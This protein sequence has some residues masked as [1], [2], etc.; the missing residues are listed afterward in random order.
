LR[1][2]PHA[3]IGSKEWS[4]H[5]GVEPEHGLRTYKPRKKDLKRVR[6]LFPPIFS[7]AL[8]LFVVSPVDATQGISDAIDTELISR[9]APVYFSGDR[10]SYNLRR[11]LVLG[12][13]RIEVIQGD[14]RLSGERVAIDLATSIAEVEG[15]VVATRLG[16]KVT[17]D[18]GVYDFEKEE[19]VFHMARGSSEPWY[20]T[21]EKV[22]REA[23]GQFSVDKSTLSTCDLPNPHYRLEAGKTDVIPEER[24]VARNLWLYAG[25]IPVFYLPY[26]SH[27]L[28]TG[29]PPIEWEAGTESDVG[30]YARVGYNIELGEQVLLNP[31]VSGFT[32]SGVGAGLDGRLNLFDGTGRG[33]FDSFYISEQNEDNLEEEGIR[34]DR[35]KIDVYYRQELPYDVTA[36]LQGEYI[37]DSEFLKTYDFDD[38]SEREL[39]ES[40]VNVERTGTHDVVSFTVRERLV[41][42]IE[43]VDRLPELKMALLEQ[44]LWDTGLFFNVLGDV[45]YLDDEEGDFQATRGFARGRLSYPVSFLNWLGLVPFVEGDGTYYSRTLEEDDEGRLT[46]DAGIVGQSRFHKIYGSPFEQYTAFRHLFVPTVTYRFRPTPDNEPEELHG[47]DEVDEIDRE[48]SLEIELKNYL[49]AKKPNGKIRDIV[50]YNFTAGLEFDDSEDTLATLENELLIRPVPN[51]EL[52]LKTVNDFRDETRADLLSGVVRYALPESIRAS[53]GLLHEDTLLKPHDTQA[54]YSLSKALGPLWRAGFAQHY[55]ISESEFTYQEFWIWRDLH[56]WEALLRVRDREESTSVTLL[57]NIKAIPLG[58]IERKTALNPLG[59][60]HPWP[61]RW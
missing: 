22:E 8:A 44:R 16:D 40:F 4:R 24:V 6:R 37:T 47:F 9:G 46:W 42:Y 32:E 27:S 28:E 50:E 51:W 36:L 52:A 17:G 35:G 55:S 49:Q 10:F 30:A 2:R 57:V 48:N 1:N 5:Q 39:P 7:I 18:K 54:I 20:V 60:N 38:F 14:A 11:R 59:E 58:R 23:G 34:Q 15:D 25:K 29:R 41:D 43:D 53:V 45:A 19:G 33:R 31:H 21:A 13:G 61:T 3:E 56:C 26:Y 12:S